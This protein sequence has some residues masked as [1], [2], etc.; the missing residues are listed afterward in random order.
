LLRIADADHVLISAIH[1][2]KMTTP[3][4]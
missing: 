2:A 4:V 3:T 1:H